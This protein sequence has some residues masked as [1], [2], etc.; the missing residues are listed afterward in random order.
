MLAQRENTPET[1]TH[2]FNRVDLI[3][4]FLQLA[5]G[6]SCLYVF[7]GCWDR[8][9]SELGEK[10]CSDTFTATLQIKPA[11]A[12]NRKN[13]SCSFS[14]SSRYESGNRDAGTDRC[15]NILDSN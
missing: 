11:Q 9:T 12:I 15:K 4:N 13:N 1:M 6:S 8:K 7:K 2:D 5:G 14:E 10:L 3:T